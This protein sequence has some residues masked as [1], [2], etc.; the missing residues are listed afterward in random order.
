MSIAKIYY[1]DA[2]IVLLVMDCDNEDSLE[3]AQDYLEMIK[4]ETSNNKVFLVVNKIDLIPNFDREKNND[5]SIY[6]DLPYY[7]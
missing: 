3:R 2:D 6:E 4:S 1:Q 7:E 5:P